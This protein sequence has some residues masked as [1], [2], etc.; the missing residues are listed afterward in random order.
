MHAAFEAHRS[1]IPAVDGSR[2]ERSLTGGSSHRGDERRVVTPPVHLLPK[3]A[4][5]S[6]AAGATRLLLKGHD[7]SVVK[8]RPPLFFDER[9]GERGGG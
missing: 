2:T 6:Q 3:T 1:G 4:T 9:E 7:S 8:V 5:L